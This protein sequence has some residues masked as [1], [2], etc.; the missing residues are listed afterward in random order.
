MGVKGSTGDFNQRQKEESCSTFMIVQVERRTD[1]L[2]E[3]CAAFKG[4]KVQQLLMVAAGRQG[5]SPVVRKVQ[6]VNCTDTHAWIPTCSFTVSENW[7]IGLIP[8]SIMK[9]Q[10]LHVDE[11]GFLLSNTRVN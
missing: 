2:R 11:M 10:S 6:R 3:L 7:Y 9:L 5:Q 4:D 1:A 8:I